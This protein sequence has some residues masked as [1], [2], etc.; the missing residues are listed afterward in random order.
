MLH[1]GAEQLCEADYFIR[2]DIAIE[3]LRTLW[4]GAPLDQRLCKD[5]GT[6]A[7]SE[8]TFRQDLDQS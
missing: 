8:D 2:S 7:E 3:Q 6:L 1:Y 5:L 4:T